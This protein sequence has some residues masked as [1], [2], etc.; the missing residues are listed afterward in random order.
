MDPRNDLRNKEAIANDLQRLQSRLIERLPRYIPKQ[1]A[2]YDTTGIDCLAAVLRMCHSIVVKTDPTRR[3]TAEDEANPLLRY[4]WQDYDDAYDDDEI[5]APQDILIA[6]A[7]MKMAA[8]KSLV[9][10]DSSLDIEKLTFKAL[11]KCKPMKETVWSKDMHHFF[12]RTGFKWKRDAN[13][14]WVQLQPAK[15]VAKRDVLAVSTTHLVSA[16]WRNGLDDALGVMMRRVLGRHDVQGTESCIFSNRPQVIRVALRS[17]PEDGVRI[18]HLAAFDLSV[19]EIVS[20]DGDRFEADVTRDSYHLMAIVQMRAEDGSPDRVKRFTTEGRPLTPAYLDNAA[21]RH[22]S[23]DICD[24]KPREYM[25]FYAIDDGNLASAMQTPRGAAYTT[26]DQRGKDLLLDMVHCGRQD[27]SLS[28][29]P[30]TLIRGWG[31]NAGHVDEPACTAAESGTTRQQEA[32]ETASEEQIPPTPTTRP[33]EALSAGR[34]FPRAATAEESAWLRQELSK[35][36]GRRP[37]KQMAPMTRA[38]PTL[39]PQTQALPGHREGIPTTAMGSPVAAQNA[40]MTT[41]PLPPAT[42][43]APSMSAQPPDSKVPTMPGF[44]RTPPTG[45]SCP[46]TGANAVPLGRNRFFQLRDEDVKQEPM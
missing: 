19:D 36:R 5:D 22:M 44:L 2:G 27:A 32:E 43:A 41:P 28:R 17:Q 25:L 24:S 14:A 18:R 1:L 13:G 20:Q 21:F 40:P 10:A 23:W 11:M 33:S 35:M 31:Q 9:Q 8:M 4:S 34:G 3:I 30:D 45:P 6:R 16:S 7:E 46:A 42:I 38:P 15:D 26:E 12:P 29:E 37:L 39:A